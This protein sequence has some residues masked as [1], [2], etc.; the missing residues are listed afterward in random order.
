MVNFLLISCCTSKDTNIQENGQT[1]MLKK[2]HAAQ[3]PPGTADVT[4]TVISVD[5]KDNVNHAIIRID[6]VHGY[7]AS[8]K[9]LAEGSEIEVLISKANEESISKILKP[10]SARKMRIRFSSRGMGQKNSWEIISLR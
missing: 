3:L 5:T 6:T 10:K 7:G 1:K 8:T 4:A 9:P 2:S